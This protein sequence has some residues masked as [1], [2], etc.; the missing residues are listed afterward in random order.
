MLKVG[1]SSP[2]D[3]WSLGCI[4][5]ELLTGEVLFGMGAAHG[6]ADNTLAHLAGIHHLLGPFPYAPALL[7]PLPPALVCMAAAS[8]SASP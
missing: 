3:M 5:V 1:W 6:Q 4:L 7:P 2:A 8:A